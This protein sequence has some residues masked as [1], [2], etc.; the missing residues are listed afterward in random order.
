[1]V[2]IFNFVYYYSGDKQL[3]EISHGGLKVHLIFLKSE[4]LGTRGQYA[5]R[6]T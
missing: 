6:I 3:K 4:E 1:M 5:Q 2:V